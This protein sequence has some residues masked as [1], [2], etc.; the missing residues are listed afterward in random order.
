M[1][2]V[3]LGPELLRFGESVGI[4]GRCIKD[5]EEHIPV[6]VW[7]FC[8]VFQCNS[9]PKSDYIKD[10][11][12]EYVDRLC[13]RACEDKEGKKASYLLWLHSRPRPYHITY[14]TRYKPPLDATAVCT[15]HAVSVRRK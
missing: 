11:Q 8:R 3:F 13:F 10:H 12:D 7:W 6:L 2:Y 4:S 15:L 14:T 9:G 5:F 1:V